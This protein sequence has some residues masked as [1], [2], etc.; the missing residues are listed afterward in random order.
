MS[1]LEKLR[2]NVEYYEA[3]CAVVPHIF[4]NEIS[5]QNCDMENLQGKPGPS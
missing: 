1:L 5:G 4:G 3:L 2:C